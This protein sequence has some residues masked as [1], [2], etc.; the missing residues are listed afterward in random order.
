MPQVHFITLF[1]EIQ[2]RFRKPL[3]QLAVKNCNSAGLFVMAVK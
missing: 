3:L 1:S 2:K